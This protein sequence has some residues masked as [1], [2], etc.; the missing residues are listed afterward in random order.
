MSKLTIALIS[1][2]SITGIILIYHYV[3]NPQIVS[4]PNKKTASQCPENWIYEDTLCKPTYP[5]SCMP[6]DPTKITSAVSACNLAKTCGTMWSGM[7]A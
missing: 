5:T 3:F 7:C 4:S 2:V 6:F 1:I